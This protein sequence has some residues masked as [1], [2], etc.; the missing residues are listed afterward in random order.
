M[1]ETQVDE[2]AIF[3]VARKIDSR[4]ARQ[5]YLQQVCGGDVDLN[6]RVVALLRAYK[7]SASFLESPPLE[8]GTSPTAE[9]PG[10]VIGPYK[11]REKIGEGGFGVVYLA[12]QH[13]PVRRHVAL[14]IIKPGMDTREVIARFEAERQALALM[15]HPN[16]AR[17]LH[18]LA[19]RAKKLQPLAGR[20]I[21]LVAVVGDGDALDQL[22]HEIGPTRFGRSGIEHAGDVGVVHKRQG[23]PLGLEAGDHLFAV[24]A[25]LDNLE[26]HAAADRL[27]LLGQID[28]PE[29]PLADPPPRSAWPSSRWRA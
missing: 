1:A 20:E 21:A 26:R 8:L 19:D 28:D 6:Q 12:E 13:D 9:C 10:T 23:L 3:E 4:E 24:H 22:H 16:I 29:A 18:R 2:Q 17:V 15:D 11:L 5:A 7:E 27:M 14:K 25:G